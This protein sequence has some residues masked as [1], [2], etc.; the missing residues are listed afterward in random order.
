MAHRSVACAWL[1]CLGIAAQA[2]AQDGLGTRLLRRPTV[3]RDLVAF[4]YGGDLWVVPRGGGQA[5]RL[6]STPEPETDPRFSPDGL[7]IAYTSTVAGNTDVYVVATAGGTPTRLT[8]HP[9][10][11]CVRGWSP[12]GKRVIF[13]SSRGTL[14]TPGNNSYFRLWSIG[15]D[16]GLPEPLPM[17]RAFAGT[18]SPDGARVAY[19]EISVAMFAAA[20]AQNQSSQ[21]RH[22]RGGRTQPIRLMKLA[23]YSV[24]KLPGPTATTPSRRGSATRCTSCRIAASRPTS[25][26]TASTRSSSSNSRTTTTSTS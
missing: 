13:G 7:R 26:R 2:F 4:A 16:G 14:P 25:S 1:V 6:T 17:P 5:R 9:G 10:V 24:E 18:Y 12:D 11:D 8:F 23:D 21:W 20:W 15:V 19:Q 3:S 22:Y